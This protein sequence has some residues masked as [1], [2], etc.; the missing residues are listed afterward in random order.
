MRAKKYFYTNQMYIN[1]ELMLIK[2]QFYEENQQFQEG[3]IN[4][5][6]IKLQC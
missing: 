6:R 4:I 2:S 5:M 1:T 3:E